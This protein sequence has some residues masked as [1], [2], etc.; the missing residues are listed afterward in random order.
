[1]VV[2]FPRHVEVTRRTAYDAFKTSVQQLNADKLKLE[3]DLAAADTSLRVLEQRLMEE[4]GDKVMAQ[5]VGQLQEQ[6]TMLRAENVDRLGEAGAHARQHEEH[7]A[8]ERE[9]NMSLRSQVEDVRQQAAAS[10]KLC[11]ALQAK[12]DAAERV[13]CDSQH[14]ALQAEP[15][16][17]DANV[18]TQEGGLQVV[19][20]QRVVESLHASSTGPLAG[21]AL[22]SELTALRK[23]LALATQ[24]LE[25]SAGFE[26]RCKEAVADKRVMLQRVEAA[27]RA[28]L[29]S[30]MWKRKALESREQYQHLEHLYRVLRD[31]QEASKAASAATAVGLQRLC[32]M[33]RNPLQASAERR[34]GDAAEA[35]E[36]CSSKTSEK[37]AGQASGNRQQAV[38]ASD[39]SVVAQVSAVFDAAFSDI[40]SDSAPRHPLQK[41]REQ[42]HPNIMQPQLMGAADVSEV[43]CLTND[44]TEPPKDRVSE[45][46]RVSAHEPSN[47]DISTAPTPADVT[48]NIALQDGAQPTLKEET[49]S[50]GFRPTEAECMALTIGSPQPVVKKKIRADAQ[51]DDSTVLPAETSATTEAVDGR[52]LDLFSGLAQG[53][54]NGQPSAPVPQEC[55]VPAHESEQANGAISKAPTPADVT[56]KE[57]EDRADAQIDDSTAVPTETRA[58][59]EAAGSMAL[60]LFSGL[61]QGVGKG[62]PSAPVSWFGRGDDNTE[63]WFFTGLSNGAQGLTLGLANGAQGLGVNL[64]NIQAHAPDMGIFNRPTTQTSKQ[65]S[66]EPSLTLVPPPPP[67]PPQLQISPQC[68]SADTSG[69]NADLNHPRRQSA[70]QGGNAQPHIAPRPQFPPALEAPS[71]AKRGSRNKPPTTADGHGHLQQKGEEPRRIEP[72]GPGEGEGGPAQ[73][74]PQDARSSGTP[75]RPRRGVDVDLKAGRLEGLV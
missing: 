57:S 12:L 10:A 74:T 56:L 38:T 15:D 69:V 42:G 24:R 66:T 68:G 28:A 45:E 53:V 27:E 54:G 37:L 2:T 39:N 19:A 75:G 47:G 40:N 62:L 6:V 20:T 63:T 16:M 1:M 30:A 14:V 23:Q 65:T 26:E 29:E 36:T 71:Q 67:P 43:Q 44:R 11:L 33:A 9:Q 17:H 8:Q 60:D 22:D 52:A 31:E 21:E 70:Q 3:H 7:L 64:N 61:V 25:A 58:T 48:L 35:M 46:C 51:K 50:E 55:R 72:P 5:L 18:Q 4:R 59:T 49:V 34:R 13:A 73:P 32:Q 41:V